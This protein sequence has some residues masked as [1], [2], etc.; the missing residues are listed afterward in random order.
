MIRP[1]EPQDVNGVF[2]AEGRRLD[3]C[4]QRRE[5]RRDH[6]QCDA[7]VVGIH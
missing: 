7:G 6:A 3:W 2:D 5:R 4:H 1:V